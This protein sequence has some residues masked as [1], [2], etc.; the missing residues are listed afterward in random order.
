[1]DLIDELGIGLNEKFSYQQKSTDNEFKPDL[2]IKK[3]K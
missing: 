1:M 2:I 3:I